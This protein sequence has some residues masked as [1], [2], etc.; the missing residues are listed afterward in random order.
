M[1]KFKDLESERQ[2][3]VNNPYGGQDVT[4][5]ASEK[6][7][8][9]LYRVVVLFASIYYLHT[10]EFYATV[11]RSPKVR[12]EWFKI[13]LAASIGL[14]IIKFYVEI[15]MGKINKATV[16]YK[17]FP[18][19]THSVMF[20]LLLSSV[21]FNTALWPAY[22]LKTLFIMTVVIGY[23]ILVQLSLLVPTYAQNVMAFVLM[24]F[25]IQEYV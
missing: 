6:I 15:F 12:H 19:S 5:S 2:P 18:K 8:N 20:L 21:A 25:F 11:L 10:L 23:G 7:L 16:S 3:L 4:Q 22:G 9:G 1:P 17:H 14:L 24:T 13:G